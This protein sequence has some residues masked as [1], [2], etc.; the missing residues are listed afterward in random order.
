MEQ[1][2]D[3]GA[4]V[5]AASLLANQFIEIIKVLWLAKIQDEAVRKPVTVLVSGTLSVLLA[6]ALAVAAEEMGFL[7]AGQRGLVLLAAWPVAWGMYQV[8][9]RSIGMIE[10]TAEETDPGGPK[11]SG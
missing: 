7:P 3:V 6:W 8:S 2:V 1:V 10:L 5:A 9:K 11:D 4:V